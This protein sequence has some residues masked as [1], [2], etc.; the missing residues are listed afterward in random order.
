[1]PFMPRQITQCVHTHRDPTRRLPV[2]Q[3]R[4]TAKFYFSRCQFFV[5]TVR[6]PTLTLRTL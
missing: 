1:M 5:Q 3:L 4:E 6:S 2:S